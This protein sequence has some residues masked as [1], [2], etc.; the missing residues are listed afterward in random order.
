MN[1]KSWLVNS[2]LICALIVTLFSGCTRS[3][4]VLFEKNNQQLKSISTTKVS[5]KPYRYKIRVHDRISVL[6]YNNPELGTRKIG[7]LNK[8]IYGILV[9]SKGYAKFPLIGAI[10]VTDYYQEDLATHLESLYS[11]YIL[12]PQINVDILNKRVI[13]LGEVKQPGVVQITNE[14]INLFEVLSRSGGLTSIGERN[15]VVIL[16]GDLSNPQMSIID[17]TDMRSIMKYNTMLEPYDIVYVV[18]NLNIIVGQ[19]LTGSQVLNLLL[20]SAVSLKTLTNF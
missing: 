19:G 6:F 18:P 16:R 20:G 7:D 12:N 4:Y 10:K 17:L 14:T 11:E 13:V 8:D 2:S 15:G 5:L 3:D 9:D 1:S